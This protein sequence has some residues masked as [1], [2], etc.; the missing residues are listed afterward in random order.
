MVIQI[1]GYELLLLINIFNMGFEKGNELYKQQE[2]LTKAQI[3]IRRSE[4][5]DMMLEGT[6]R[7]DILKK[8]MKKYGV[9]ENTVSLDIHRLNKN[10]LHGL[11]LHKASILGLHLNRYEDLYRRFM[12]KKGDDYDLEKAAK[13]LEKK[14]KLLKLHNPDVVINSIENQQVNNMNLSH[15]NTDELKKLLERDEST[16]NNEQGAEDALDEGDREGTI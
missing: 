5:Y 3:E 15:Y 7:R 14:E 1:R 8:I 9:S 10:V 13:M 11:Q 6:K 4:V 2:G 16:G 12:D